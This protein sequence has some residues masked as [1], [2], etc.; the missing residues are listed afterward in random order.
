MRYNIRWLFITIKTFPGTNIRIGLK[1]KKFPNYLLPEPLG[2]FFGDDDAHY[3]GG[4]NSMKQSSIVAS[5]GWI[6]ISV[7]PLSV[8]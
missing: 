5:M 4:D 1:M 3:C 6:E 2:Q 8:K 7:C